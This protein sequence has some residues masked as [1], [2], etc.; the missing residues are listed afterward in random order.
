M[1]YLTK[2]KKEELE[3]ELKKLINE[4][5]LESAKKIADALEDNANMAEN[6]DFMVAREEKEKLEIRISHLEDILKN[7][8][9]LKKKKFERVDVG[10]TV[11]VRK[12]GTKKDKIFEIVGREE[13]DLDSKKIALDAP[14]AKA[15]L[16]KKEKEEFEFIT[17][18]GN[19]NKYVIKL[20]S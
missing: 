9:I 5:R 11:V 4:G 14:L 7:V 13:F 8:E 18:G 10:A 16:G 1:Y 20:I 19:I 6:N 2:E 3:E 17:P 15:M 12:K